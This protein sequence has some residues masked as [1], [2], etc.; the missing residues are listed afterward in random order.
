MR[1]APDTLPRLAARSLTILVLLC[2]LAWYQG[3]ALVEAL[4]PA[5]HA[6]LNWLDNTYRI[7][8]LT[9]TRLGGEQVIRLVVGLA[10][11]I[12]VTDHAYCAPPQ[13][14][15]SAST[16][17]GHVLMPAICLVA[18]VL[19]WPSRSQRDT[20]YRLLLLPPAVILIWTLDVPFVL[21]AALW[22]LHVDTF[23]PGMWSPL[24]GWSQFLE[25]GGRMALP[26]LGAL[27][28]LQLASRLSRPRALQ[29]LTTV[30]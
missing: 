29:A 17:A 15:G 4:L 14:Q 3:P 9:L 1:Q 20:T 18:I 24:L 21:W 28:T 19:A 6:E 30:A 10:H 12:V 26:V 11:C 2:T 7:D 23:A 13:A 5:L 8:E 25:S 16:L 27:A 22:S